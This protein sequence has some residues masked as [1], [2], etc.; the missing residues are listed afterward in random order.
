M[1]KA[2][3]GFRRG[4]FAVV[5]QFA[6]AYRVQERGPLSAGDD[7]VAEVGVLGVAHCSGGFFGDGGDLDAVLAVGAAQGGLVETEWGNAGCLCLFAF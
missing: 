3:T 1:S 4:L 5:L 6:V 7:E 2:L